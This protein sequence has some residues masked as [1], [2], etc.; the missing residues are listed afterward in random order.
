[1]CVCHKIVRIKPVNTWE[2]QK[3]S[4]LRMHKDQSYYYL[5]AIEGGVGGKTV[6]NL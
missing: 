1:M 2:P 4:L 5:V 3:Q 6:C